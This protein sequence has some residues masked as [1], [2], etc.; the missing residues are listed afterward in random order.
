MTISDTTLF[1]S[2]KDMTNRERALAVLN[3]QPY[4]RLPIVH[5]GFW[6]ETVEIWKQQGFFTTDDLTEQGWVSANGIAK[7]GFDFEWDPQ[8]YPY[9]GI[10]PIFE[11]KVIKELPDGAQQV[12]NGDGVIVLQKPD[13]GS[14]PAEIAHLLVD[15]ASWEEHYLPRLQYDESR[16]PD[17]SRFMTDEHDDLRGIHIGSLFGMIRNWVGV[18]GSAYIY[19]DDEELFDEMINVVGDL[20]YQTSKTVLERGAKFDFGH[21][22][23]DICFKN[24]P[25]ITPNVFK[26]KVGPHYRRITEMLKEYGI[27]IVSL[28]CDGMIDSLIP[29]WFENG[30]NTMFPIEV[31]T[32]E[33]SIAPWREKY[34]KELRGVGGMNKL[35]FAYDHA[36]IDAEIERMKPLVDLGGFI[37]CPDHRIAPDGKWDL[38]RYYCEKMRDTF[39]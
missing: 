15:R 24:G 31:G 4:D 14:I 6:G 32:W 7:L 11:T 33:A 12:Q 38:V 29:T 22:W 17:F 9:S 39:G 21:F 5:F 20:A 23:E 3:Y 25:L 16:I 28:D 8:C 36:A 35:A 27:T 34:G 13:A 18:T 19:A 2:E 30:V 1:S 37:P 26:E 10:K